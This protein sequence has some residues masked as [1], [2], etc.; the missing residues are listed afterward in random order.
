MKRLSLLWLCLLL[1][2]CQNY[3][4]AKLTEIPS[5]VKQSIHTA[6][7]NQHRP[8]VVIALVNPNGTYFYSYGVSQTNSEKPLSQQSQ[9]AIGSLTKL[10][11]AELLETLDS[12]NVLSQQTLL[13]DIWP[14]V[15][16]NANTRLAYLVNH[17]A[18]LPR[19]LSHE[20]LSQNSTEYL[21]ATLS[22][23]TELPADNSYSS[24]G[25]AILGLSLGRVTDSSF[26]DQLNKEILAPL[27]LTNTGFTPHAEILATR[28]QTTIPIKSPAEVPEVA[29][30]AGGLYSTANDLVRFLKHEMQQTKH[31]GWKHYQDETFDA[32]YHGGDG[33]G[34]Q[35]FIAFRPDNNVGV[36]LLSNS[37]SDDALQ[38]IALHLIDPRL[39]LPSFEHRPHQQLSEKTLSL[40]TGDY[41]LK[42]DES[43]NKIKL[44]VIDS[45]LVYHELTPEGDTVRQTPLH[46][47]D[48]KTFELADMPVVISFES[49]TNK[50]H[51][52]LTFEGQTFSMVR[53]N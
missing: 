41:R 29:Y 53:L 5:D 38:D 44:N 10:F 50:S 26:S 3:D 46:A 39:D 13:T 11:T 37:A 28:H 43:G 23:E 22:R 25:M 8:G 27:K 30:G 9:F 14:D 48:E 2:A 7:N 51:A 34:H 32:F 35:A 6:V 24:V 12:K 4:P 45:R 49:A 15:E 20:T 33:N 19:D 17:T 31:L 1:S 52:I 47:I 42:E 36:V 16:D 40:Y 21:L 18:A